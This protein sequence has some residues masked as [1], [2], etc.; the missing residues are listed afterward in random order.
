MRCCFRWLGAAALAALLPVMTPVVNGHSMGGF[1]GGGAH[2]AGGGPHFA[3]GGPHFAGGGPHFSR[4]SPHFAMGHGFG[5]PGAFRQDH[6]FFDGN[7]RFADRDHFD[8]DRFF[9]HH[10]RHHT[11]FAFDF[12]AFGFPWWYPYPYP[13]Y[14]DYPYAYSYDD[15]G[16]A[17]DNDY[18]SNLAVAVQS[19]LARRG[20]YHD[21]I[22][23]VIGS[24]SRQ[25]IRAFQAARGLPVTGIIDPNLLKALGISYRNA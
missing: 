4:G 24:G 19:E 7:H 15:Y 18:W 10:H 2:F 3:G 14:Y 9:F 16:Q 17:Y 1:A 12:A 13:Y 11:F 5:H 20:Y 6:R 25:A 21:G 22:D 8:H 23:G